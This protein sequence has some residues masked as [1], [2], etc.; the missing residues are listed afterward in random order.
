MLATVMVEVTEVVATAVAAA[1]VLVMMVMAQTSGRGWAAM[2]AVVVAGLWWVW[3]CG[4]L[5]WHLVVGG[6]LCWCVVW[7]RGTP[8]IEPNTV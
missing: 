3:G 2:V 5:R 8:N 4:W 7:W 1:M 6:V